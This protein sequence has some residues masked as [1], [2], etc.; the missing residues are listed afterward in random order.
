[1]Q[2]RKNQLDINELTA[3]LFVAIR[4]KD[5]NDIRKLISKGA[6]LAGMNEKNLTPIEFA[7]NCLAWKC[8][9]VI[10]ECKSTDQ[11]DTYR[12][13]SAL[14]EAVK[15]KEHKAAACLLKAKS[16][17][18]WHTRMNGYYAIHWA[19]KNDDI[20]MIAL[21]LDHG[22]PLNQENNNK[23]TPVQLAT[24]LNRWKCVAQ[25]AAQ[26]ETNRH[27]SFRY[28]YALLYAVNNDNTELA[29]SL[30]QAKAPLTWSLKNGHY[31]SIHLAVI[32]NNPNMLAILLQFNA[33]VCAVNKE[34]RTAVELACQSG[35]WECA[36][37]LIN[38]SS[39]PAFASNESTRVGNAFISA[40]K[41]GNLKIA[42]A[43]GSSGIPAKAVISPD[44]NSCF[45]ALA[46][47]CPTPAN[48]NEKMLYI[49]K[50]NIDPHLKNKEG[51][52]AMDLA[53]DLKQW[54]FIEAFIKNFPTSEQARND[55]MHLA[56]EN[57]NY[58]TIKLL[59]ESHV[60]LPDKKDMLLT[61]KLI[62]VCRNSIKTLFLDMCDKTLTFQELP[63]LIKVFRFY[64]NIIFQSHLTVLISLRTE[65]KSHVLQHAFIS[66]ALDKDS[67][68]G[69]VTTQIE[70]I[71]SILDNKPGNLPIAKIA[72]VDSEMQKDIHD[73]L[74]CNEIIHIY[75]LRINI[76]LRE[77]EI[78]WNEQ[79]SRK[80]YLEQL[81]MK[82][83]YSL[84]LFYSSIQS[85]SNTLQDDQTLNILIQ[86]TSLLRAL[87]SA[88][89]SEKDLP[90][91]L[92]EF[93]K[94]A[95]KQLSSIAFIPEKARNTV[96]RIE[97]T[98]LLPDLHQSTSTPA[99]AP[100]SP[101]MARLPMPLL[102]ELPKSRQRHS[103]WD[104]IHQDTNPA[105]SLQN[106]NGYTLLRQ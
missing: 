14:L 44:G 7:S 29:S 22:C 99:S 17:F 49:R 90:G 46:K 39:F 57:F 50:F 2:D 61:E 58:S 11:Q 35:F 54:D 33:S 59:L 27:D 77:I 25:I 71:T 55:I 100:L 16:P 73:Y 56:I 68:L 81:E 6:N 36:E 18:R 79:K 106:S 1:M 28:G 31:L 87:E 48:L 3:E 97:Q 65:L 63:Y 83:N 89:E 60:N 24:D 4:K 91:Y 62:H 13:G 52:T 84:N 5:E 19:I 12:Y 40:V 41:S 105:P 70:I 95:T 42:E 64:F 37:L 8:V 9:Q 98:S 20:Q 76:A 30:L 103:F 102:T 21:L 69:K 66:A 78:K 32:N 94:L 45:H 53:L 15:M 96:I 92:K 67:E 104:V 10:A 26:K 88:L 75:L 72:N 38:H 47:A 85:L 93:Y 80:G 101:I 34:N 23:K 82:M 43:L 86:V 74:E 51:K